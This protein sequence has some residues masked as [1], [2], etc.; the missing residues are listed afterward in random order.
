MWISAPLINARPRARRVIP[1][2]DFDEARFYPLSL[3]FAP[4]SSGIVPEIDFIFQRRKL[5]LST[6]TR[7]I[8]IEDR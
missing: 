8:E 6:K 5:Y 1:M 4:F 2:Y 7:K 3:H